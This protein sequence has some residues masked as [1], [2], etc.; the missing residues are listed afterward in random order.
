[1]VPA[2]AAESAWLQAGKSPLERG[3]GWRF[4]MKRSNERPNRNF[5]GYHGNGR[6]WRA[7][8]LV[9]GAVILMAAAVILFGLLVDTRERQI[10]L[11]EQQRSEGARSK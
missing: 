3:L 8:A 9:I 5:A 7:A 6:D 2:V 1:M 10:L 11:Q 4:P